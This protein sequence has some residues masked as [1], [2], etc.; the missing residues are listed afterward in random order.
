MSEAF[1][2]LADRAAATGWSDKEVAAALAALA[3][4]RMLGIAQIDC[5]ETNLASIK[6]HS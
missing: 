5:L 6:K 1:A 2:E 3:D 4:N